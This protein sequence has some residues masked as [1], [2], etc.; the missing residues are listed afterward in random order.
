M[1]TCIDEE[2]GGAGEGRGVEAALVL[3]EV[4]AHHR[5]QDE[6]HAGGGVEV[7]HHQRAL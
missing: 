7:S 5:A 2:D 4:A 6:A 1:L 3:G